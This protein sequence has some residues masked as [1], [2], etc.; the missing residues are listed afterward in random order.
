MILKTLAALSSRPELKFNL[1]EQY[2]YILLDEFQDTNPVQFE[3]VRSLA[4]HPVHEGRPN[5]MAVGDDDQG[6]FAFQGADIGNMVEFLSAFR[7]VSVINLVQ[8][9]RSHP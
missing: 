1:Q 8:N 4:D 2:Q 7:D 5:I 3:L 9:Y 6:I